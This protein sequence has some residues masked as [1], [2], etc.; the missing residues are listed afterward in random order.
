MSAGVR[1]SR[2]YEPLGWVLVRAPLLPIERYL[3]LPSQEAPTASALTDPLVRAA[4]A[5]GS[6]NLLAQLD[7]GDE[8]ARNDPGIGNKLLRYLIRMSA[9]ATPFGLFAGVALA[10]WGPTTELR[11]TAALPR[12]RTRPDMAW[13]L[14]FVARL[15]ARPEIRRQVAVV[16]NPG[17]WQHGGRAILDEAVA[18]NGSGEAKPVDIRATG[19]VRR[20]LDLARTPVRW[21]DLAIDLGSTPGATEDK[22]DALLTRMWHEGFLITELRP[23]LTH[24]APARYVEQR[25]AKLEA[26]APEH[27]LLVELLD[28]M[29]AWDSCPVEDR[30]RTHR[31][32]TRRAEEALPDFEG[33]PTQVDASLPL[34]GARIARS[35]GEA[36]ARAAELLVRFSPAPAAAHLAAYC[37]TFVNHYGTDREVP[38]LELLDPERGLGPPAGTRQPSGDE[39]AAVRRRDTKLRA[40]GLRALRDRRLVVEVDEATLSELAPFGADPRTAPLSVDLSIFVL[41]RTYADVDDGRFQLMIGPNLGAQSA[42]RNLGRFADLLDGPGTEALRTVAAAEVERDPGALHAELVY[43]PRRSR[44]ANVAIRP[45]VH[46]YEIAVSTTPGV[47]PACSIPLSEVVVG[48]RDGSMYARWLRMPDDLHVHVGHMLTS[49]AAPLPCRFLEDITAG[50]RRPLSWFPWGPME[51]L[52]FLPRIEVGRVVLSPAQWQIDGTQLGESPPPDGPRFAEWLRR[53]RDEWMV[54]R[55]VYLATGDNRLLLDLEAG[56]QAELLR[57]ELRRMGSDGVVLLQEAL[58]GPEHAWLEGPDG[59]HVPELVVPLVQR[60]TA[61][62]EAGPT[63]RRAFATAAPIS[64]RVRP[65]GSDWLYV[66][67]YGPR[68]GQNELLAGPVRML[69]DFATANGTAAQWFFVRYAD[70]KPHIRLRFGG[71]PG[72]LLRELLPYICSWAQDLITDGSCT[73]LTFATYEREVER[74]GGPTA[75][76]VAEAIFSVDSGA[77]AE[78]LAIARGGR[79]SLDPTAVAAVSVDSLLVDLGLDEPA[80]LALYRDSGAARRQ[81]GAEYRHRK[82]QLRRLLGGRQ[83]GPDIAGEPALTRILQARRASMAPLVIR[84][85]ALAAGGELT[86]PYDRICQSIVHMHCNRLLNGKPPS[87]QEVLGLLLRTRESL[88]R[89]PVEARRTPAE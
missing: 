23:P 12:T 4:L 48:V 71:H 39:S 20:A 47:E 89:A 14:E 74:Y 52:P 45:P 36:A 21:A 86:K 68:N 83:P 9:R 88:E 6:P 1:T 54:P 50:Q 85:E 78:M 40:I 31:A 81:T 32:L 8:R 24:P 42:G 87:E 35:V 22:V 33:A 82:V 62:A 69:G 5:V 3:E 44:I 61:H 38:M 29:A 11:L 2:L 57:E 27:A 76:S 25:M 65:P 58:P 77:V 53:W 10:T 13:L 56:A 16:T 51:T 72:L 15:E 49:R 55:R 73:E 37:Q 70:P 64:D 28:A 19:A 41:A 17:V 43:L 59:H 67:L 46:R 18:V 60:R 30:P 26:A 7:R 34:G 80:R 75:M 66:K 84:L 79:T 63:T